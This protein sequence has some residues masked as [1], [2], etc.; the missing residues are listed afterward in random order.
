VDNARSK[1]DLTR[2]SYK[3]KTGNKRKLK[4][5]LILRLGAAKPTRVILSL[6]QNINL[7]VKN[8]LSFKINYRPI[9]IN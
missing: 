2:I 3:L 6:S 1:Q 4:R 5:K 8:F 7:T 9:E